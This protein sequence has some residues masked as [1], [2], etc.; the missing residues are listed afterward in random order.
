M[1][2]KKENKKQKYWYKFD[3]YVCPLCGREDNYKERIYDKQKPELYRDR[4]DYHE[5]WDGCGI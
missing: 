3:H 4:H 2:I 1:K 5:V